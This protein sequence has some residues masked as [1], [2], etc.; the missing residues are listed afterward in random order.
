M[1]ISKHTWQEV[2][3]IKDYVQNHY[4]YFGLYP[5][6]VTTEKKVYT[7]NQYWTIL[8]KEF[9]NGYKRS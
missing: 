8:E 9:L 7:F 6:S 3:A 2:E 1:T 5:D 4:E